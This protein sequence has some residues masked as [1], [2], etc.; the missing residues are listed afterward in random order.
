MT[1]IEIIPTRL[2]RQARIA[3]WYRMDAAF[4]GRNGHGC[5]KQAKRRNLTRAQL[6]DM[7]AL[8]YLDGLRAQLPT[9]PTK[10]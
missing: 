8:S 10:G 9:K 4:R 7:L 6:L 3:V 5:V 2:T 1:A